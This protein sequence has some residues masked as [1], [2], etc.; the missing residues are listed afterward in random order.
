MVRSPG[1][2]SMDII[3]SLLLFLMSQ[4]QDRQVFGKMT[5]ACDL[6]W[7]GRKKGSSVILITVVFVWWE[8]ASFVKRTHS[9]L[10]SFFTMHNSDSLLLSS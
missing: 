10:L 6:L 1:L 2:Q 9:Y 4:T 7:E 3:L 5:S 8:F